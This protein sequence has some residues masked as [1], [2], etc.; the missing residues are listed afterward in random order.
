MSTGT[1]VPGD[2]RLTLEHLRTLTAI[3]DHG[4]FQQAGQVLCRTQ[5]AVTQS[6]KRLEE[7]LGCRLMTRRH[8]RFL[9]LTPAGRMFLESARDILSRAREA[10]DAVARPGLSGRLRLGVPDDFTLS[11]ITGLVARFRERWPGL[12]VETVSALSGRLFELFTRRELD[13]AI[14]LR[15]ESTD[16]LPFPT[17]TLCRDIRSIPLVWA[18]R[19]NFRPEIAGDLPLVSFPEGCAYRRAAIQALNGV[20]RAYLVV[21]ESASGENIRQAVSAGLGAA[22]LPQSALGPDHVAAEKY[23]LPPL[24]GVRLILAVRPDAP[25]ALAFAD[26]I[27]P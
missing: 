2:R 11:D 16:A 27:A 22:A 14:L 7:I 20:G 17:G 19:A 10:A 4:G 9:G 15:L 25:A 23:G 18:I 8:G 3:A 1:A 6:L 12:D 26:L 13:L 24:P 5:S 21:Y